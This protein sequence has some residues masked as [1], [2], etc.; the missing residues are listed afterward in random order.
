MTTCRPG[1]RA[2]A[3]ISCSWSPSRVPTDAVPGSQVVAI[4]ERY[5]IAR[6]CTEAAEAG[7]NGLI[8]ADVPPDDG[9][10]DLQAGTACI[11]TREGDELHEIDAVARRSRP[12]GRRRR[13]VARRPRSARRARPRG[14]G[15]EARDAVALDDRARTSSGS[16]A[17]VAEARARRG[18]HLEAARRRHAGGERGL[19]GALDRRAVGERVGVRDADLDR[20]R[21]RRDGGRGRA[22]AAR[23]RPSGRS[24][25]PACA[26][27]PALRP[28]TVSTSL[29]P[30]PERQTSTSPSGP[31]SRASRSAAN[32][33]CD[34]S[35]AGMMPSQRH[36]RWNAS[37]ASSSLTRTYS[38]RPCRPGARARG[39][40]RGSRA[41]PR[42]SASRTTWPCSSQST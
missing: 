10:D 9:G 25:A 4:V 41:R 3:S 17:R 36:S 33:A 7:A 40:R 5:G 32:S 26:A 12:A 28:T 2:T 30:R 18:E 15:A 42:S 8:V 6:F 19:G 11:G 27:S 16:A 29:S 24:P 13:R 34:D 14:V 35:S 21:A 22:R 37:S 39:R 1:L 23:R 20:R 31:S 38:A